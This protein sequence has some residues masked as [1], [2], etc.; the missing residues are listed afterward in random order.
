MRRDVTDGADATDGTD[1][2][3]VEA[4]DAPDVPE[5]EEYHGAHELREDREDVVVEKP[6]ATPEVDEEKPETRH[7]PPHRKAWWLPWR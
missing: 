4:P 3:L 1:A 7:A 2:E 5:A 6:D